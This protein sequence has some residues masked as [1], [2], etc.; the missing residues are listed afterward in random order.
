MPTGINQSKL[1]LFYSIKLSEQQAFFET[2]LTKW[3]HELLQIAPQAATFVHQIHDHQ[4]LSVA[5]YHDVVM[6]Y[7]HDDGAVVLG[8]AAHALS[9]QLGQGVNLALQDAA[10]LAT[11]IQTAPNLA[12]ALS[13]YSIA[14]TKQL[15][16]Y[17]FATRS[18]TPMFQSKSP[19][20]GLI[21]DITFPVMA[22]S[23]W[24]K[25]QM[26][27]SMAGYKDGLFSS[28]PVLM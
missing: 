23:S 6:P 19:L 26:V 8:D 5:A 7:W 16:F 3:K 13:D 15:R 14:R 11:S 27:L 28:R 25:R 1:S 18:I 4:Q 24:V 2:P 9:P 10:A 21:R 12:E 22:K 17:Q 20:L